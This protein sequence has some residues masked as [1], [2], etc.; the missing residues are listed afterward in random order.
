MSKIRFAF[1]LL[2][3][4][5]QTFLS[6]FWEIFSDSILLRFDVKETL[7][8]L[9]QRWRNLAN[10]KLITVC[11]LFMKNRALFS[12]ALIIFQAFCSFICGERDLLVWENGHYI[13]THLVRPSPSST[14]LPARQ[15]SSNFWNCYFNNWYPNLYQISP[16]AVQVLRWT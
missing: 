3:K 5:A 11:T 6:V 8:E 14:K 16:D 4:N 15:W 2:N 7:L 9:R 13:L 12:Q 10:R 1:S